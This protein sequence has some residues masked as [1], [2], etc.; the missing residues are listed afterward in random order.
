MKNEEGNIKSMI[1]AVCKS[2]NDDW[3]FRYHDKHW[4]QNKLNFLALILVDVLSH[5]EDGGK[6]I[7]TVISSFESGN[8]KQISLRIEIA[9]KISSIEKLKK[10]TYKILNEVDSIIQ[11]SSFTSSDIVKYYIHSS[12]ILRSLDEKVSKL[13]FEKAV[14][15][16]S[17]I[18]I[19]AQEQIKC[20]YSLSQLGISSDNP[21]LAFE[22]ARFVE[23]CKSRLDGYDNFP[24]D[25]GIKG[26][27]YLDCATSFAIICRWSHRYVTKIIE[28]ILPILKISVEKGFI[29]PQI[30][31]SMLPL[32]IYYWKS[33]VEYIEVLINKFDSL[34]DNRQKSIFIKNVLRDIQINCNADEKKETV[35]SIYNTIKNGRFMDSDL[36]HK[37]AGYHN[38]IESLYKNKHEEKNSSYNIKNKLEGQASVDNKIRIEKTTIVS[39]PSLNEALKKIRSNAEYY[40]AEPEISQFLSEVKNA[41][42]P[43]DYE[44]HLDTLI[45]V[46]TDLISLHSFEIALKERFEDWNY[47]PLVQNW[48]KRNFKK[49]LKI[50]FSNFNRDDRIYYDG[51]NRFASVFSIN[52]SEL[53]V[54]LFEMLPEKIDELAA[55][56]IYQT[57]AFLKNRL[58]QQEN[59]ELISWV[60]LR[61]NSKLNEDFADGIWSE[62]HLPPKDSNQVIAQ[63][64]RFVLGNPDKRIR[65]RGMHAL[66]RTVNSGNTS[67]LQILLSL[68]NNRS[69]F[70]FQHE[71]HIYFWISAKLYLWIC[72]ERLSRE[73]PL[74]VCQFKEDIFQE[75]Q[76]KELPHA[77]I[78]YFIKQSCLN[79]I[80]YD[81][82]LFSSEQTI[83]INSILIS[84][85]T[86]VREDRLKRKP[87]KC[88]SQKGN[89]KFDFDSMDTLPYWYNQLGRCFNLSENDV[90]DLADKYISEK[91][92]I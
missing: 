9:R 55:T 56:S 25:E 22:F 26:I 61:W 14:E 3:E 13:Y 42:N 65:W 83:V 86:L 53:A 38:F 88:N 67:I 73:N 2:I 40:I 60:L 75:L 17:E 34:S 12:R 39:T 90:A 21:H 85:L 80:E 20:L 58:N 52:D 48:K 54:I 10:H 64:I 43:E 7:E 29:S 59:E 47:H 62:K 1:Q 41:C 44:Q 6:L 8:H 89:W 76:N 72:I 37:F 63:T 70:P 16:V 82:S 77:L 23:F 81:N 24:L 91:W 74:V 28:H 78:L 19:E 15:A 35:E 69:C 66:R 49:A 51:I 33:Y 36:V 31:S 92:G 18:D 79:L 45:D 84:K 71:S 11:E 87:R 46:N 50:W 57:I 5:I 32:N 30:G 68:Q 4:A 27:A